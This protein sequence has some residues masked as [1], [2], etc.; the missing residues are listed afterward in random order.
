MVLGFWQTRRRC[1]FCI[2][3]VCSASVSSLLGHFSL[4]KGA[5]KGGQEGASSGCGSSCCRTKLLEQLPHTGGTL[6]FGDSSL[7]M[8]SRI[9][10]ALQQLQQ[11]LQRLH[12]L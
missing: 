4:H 5:G 1:S 10:G 3:G 12:S 6:C 8:A 11:Q 9:W 2:S 7:P